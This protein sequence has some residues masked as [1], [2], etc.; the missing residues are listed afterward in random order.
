MIDWDDD[1]EETESEDRIL[2]GVDLGQEGESLKIHLIETPSFVYI[3]IPSSVIKADTFNYFYDGSFPE[4][5]HKQSWGKIKSIPKKIQ[6]TKSR[7]NINHRFILK[8]PT[9]ESEKSPRTFSR[10]E[11]QYESEDYGWC[12]KKEY[13]NL[14]SLYEYK[15]DKQE[16][17]IINHPFKIVEHLKL[18]EEINFAGIS[19]PAIAKRNY[20]NEV[21]NVYEN[22]LKYNIIDEIVLPDLIHH[23]RPCALSSK[24]SYAIIRNHVRENIDK[25]CAEI[26]S[27]YNFCF[28]VKKQIKIIDP[29]I[30]I[31]TKKKKEK[32]RTNRSVEIF[33]MTWSPENYKGYTPIK[34][35]YGKNAEDLKSNI[36]KYLKD[37]MDMI[38]RPLV[39]CPHCNGAG[40]VEKQ[41]GIYRSE[42]VKD[43][44][45][46]KLNKKIN[47]N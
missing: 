30:N 20:S 33:E 43:E 7:P 35:F 13:R 8:D 41:M 4:P 40:V 14:E 21:Y 2:H 16:P 34:P 37:L 46:E 11:C 44:L 42:E 28:T 12:W 22:N 29:N 36:N 25:E 27:D 31:E 1:F 9:F 5:T 23:M 17:E 3:K 47:D 32:F 15:Y 45:K 38:N 6:S 26:T 18:D 39:E 24:D 10:E 19:I